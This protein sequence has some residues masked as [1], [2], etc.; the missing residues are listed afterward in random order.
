MSKK[1]KNNKPNDP[2]KTMEEALGPR[3][4][5][6]APPSPPPLSEETTQ[7][8]ANI[9][10]EMKLNDQYPEGDPA[11]PATESQSTP[12]AEEPETPP[13]TSK[14]KEMADTP[15][16][17]SSPQPVTEPS[18][19]E[20][21]APQVMN[22]TTLRRVLDFIA[23]PEF[24]PDWCRAHMMHI[25]R[26]PSVIPSPT[27]W[28]LPGKAK[29]ELPLLIMTLMQQPGFVQSNWS[30]LEMLM[31]SCIDNTEWAVGVLCTIAIFDAIRMIPLAQQMA[32]EEN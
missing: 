10:A 22:P 28:D 24:G 21:P 7:G 17:N 19:P 20:S 31:G 9:E 27:A 26:I 14:T 6:E 12:K 23:G 29:D 32:A 13:D 30:T 1:K 3:A 5:E 11:P 18:T 8:I 25:S 16:S 4:Q 2:P 15:V